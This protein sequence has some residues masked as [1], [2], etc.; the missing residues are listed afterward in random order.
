MKCEHRRANDNPTYIPLDVD[1]NEL[2]DYR[3]NIP[4]LTRDCGENSTLALRTL[5]GLCPSLFAK[6][7]KRGRGEVEKDRGVGN[8]E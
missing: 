4:L 5:W 1:P 7:E 6:G 3:H 2:Y 8:R